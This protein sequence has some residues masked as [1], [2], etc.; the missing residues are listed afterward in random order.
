MELEYMSGGRNLDR[1]GSAARMA[2][3]PSWLSVGSLLFLAH[4]GD[5]SAGNG[6]NGSFARNLL[7]DSKAT[8]KPLNLA[9]AGAH[10]TADAHPTDTAFF[11]QTAS[12][13][14]GARGHGVSQN[15]ALG[16]SIG[17]H[18][19]IGSDVIASGGNGARNGSDSHFAGVGVD[20]TAAIDNPVDGAVAGY[21]ATASA[22]QTN[23]VHF[24]QA[25][26]QIAGVGEQ[27]GNG[28]AAIGGVDV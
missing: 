20:A 2:S 5:K 15:A 16:R 6:R 8:F 27:G 28:N 22:N 4:T 23:T 9:E 26:I 14:T 18:G 21:H 13:I 24:D 19:S 12:Q 1:A 17:V 25:V 10:A 7:N 3:I 11:H